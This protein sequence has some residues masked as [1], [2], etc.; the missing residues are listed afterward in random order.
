MIIALAAIAALQQHDALAHAGH[1]GNQ[2]AII[3]VGKD[4]GAH[5][6]LDHQ[7]AAARPDWVHPA[8]TARELAALPAL[9]DRARSAFGLIAARVERSRY[10]LRALDAADWQAARE[11]YAAF[12]LERIAA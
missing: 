8:S 11:A 6:H 4:L 3:I 10:A 12:A 2:G 5:G 9:P 1:V 7:I